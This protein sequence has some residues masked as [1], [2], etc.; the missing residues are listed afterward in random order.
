MHEVRG[1][2]VVREL[3]VRLRPRCVNL[4]VVCGTSLIGMH[5][6]RERHIHSFWLLCSAAPL[7][8]KK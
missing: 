7:Y 2:G 3:A 4:V 5:T 8:A 6:Q 1:L